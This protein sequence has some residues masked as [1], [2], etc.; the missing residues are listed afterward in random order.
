LNFPSAQSG[1]RPV[2]QGTPTSH[3]EQA[4]PTRS[5]P[6]DVMDASELLKV[7]RIYVDK[8]GDDAIAKEMQSMIFSALVGSKRFQGDRES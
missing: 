3:T 2:A 5:G 8:F 6:V 7:K 1:T 4:Q